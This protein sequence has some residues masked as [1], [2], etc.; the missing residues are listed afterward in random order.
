MYCV[1]ISSRVVNTSSNCRHGRANVAC[2]DL[3]LPNKRAK[4]LVSGL[5]GVG[6]ANAQPQFYFSFT[7]EDRY[8][9][10]GGLEV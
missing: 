1:V 8:T 3:S 6:C 10:I 9:R 2:L 5:K 7:Y 4:F